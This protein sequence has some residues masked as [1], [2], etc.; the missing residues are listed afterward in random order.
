M[1]YPVCLIIYLVCVALFVALWSAICR[2]EIFLAA[3]PLDAGGFDPFLFNALAFVGS[4]CF[5]LLLKLLLLTQQSVEHGA[6]KP[7]QNEL[8]S[9][10]DRHRSLSI[11]PICTA[12]II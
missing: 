4:R 9:F 3:L 7:Q 8:P 1:L 5:V 12:G 6:V 11:V 10:C 2:P